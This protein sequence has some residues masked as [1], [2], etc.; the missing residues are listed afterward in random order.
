MIIRR[1]LPLVLS[2][3]AMVAV[4]CTGATELRSVPYGFLTFVARKAASGYTAS[5]TGTFYSASGLGVPTA[6]APWDSCRVQSYSVTSG[7]VGLGS[8]FP[9]MNAGASIQLKLPSRTDS[10]FPA[11]LGTETQYTPRNVSGIPYTPGD[12]VAVVIPGATGD[13]GYPGITFKGKTAEAFVLENFGTP[14]VGSGIALRWNAGQDLNSTMV[15]SFRY[16]TLGSD[17]LSTQINCQFRD[18]GADSIPTRYVA[19]WVV[20][21]QKTWIASRVR[22]YVAPVSKGGY[23][24]FIST[25]DI[26]TPASP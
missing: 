1:A 20:A 9:S 12:S 2:A 10:L 4:A 17:A 19:A 16:S 22:T 14:E 3:I 11:T 15:F 18:D 13:L 8:V 24:D 26:P 5:P 21:V 25:Y 6:T 23:F 7:S